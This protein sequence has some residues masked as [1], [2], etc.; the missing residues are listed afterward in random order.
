MTVEFL[1]TKSTLNLR[2]DQIG[3]C[4]VISIWLMTIVCDLCVF[5]GPDVSVRQH[6][7]YVAC[8]HGSVPNKDH[9]ILCEPGA[10]AVD[11]ESGNLITAVLSCPPFT[12]FTTGLGCAGHEYY[13]KGIKVRNRD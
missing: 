11:L 1:Q 8:A 4:Q 13:K 7:E 6:S 2:N 5:I 3:L 9:D 12:C 10:T